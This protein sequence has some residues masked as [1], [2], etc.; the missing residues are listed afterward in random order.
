[1]ER[2]LPADAAGAERSARGDTSALPFLAAAIARFLQEYPWTGDGLSRS[3][4]RL[5]ELANAG[6]IDLLAAF[7]RMHDGE[8]AYYITDTSLDELADALSGASPPL[9]SKECDQG[10]EE[11]EQPRPD[12]LGDAG[13]GP[14]E[15]APFARA[16]VLAF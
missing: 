6:P 15:R 1:M 16:L 3:E 5:L 11:D 2:V 13:V 8:R 14:D 9:Q 12:V 4:R 7:P 10:Q